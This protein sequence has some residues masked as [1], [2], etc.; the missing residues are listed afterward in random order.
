MEGAIII[1]FAPEHWGELQKF[2]EFYP[3]TYNLNPNTT[4]AVS[5]ALNHFSK[6]IILKNLSFKLKPNLE[7]DK[8]ELDK[9]GYSK[10]INSRELSAVIEAIILELYSSI[11]CTRK[12]VGEIYKNLQGVPNS[13]RKFFRNALENKLDENFPEQMKKAFK[14]ATWYNEF[15]KIRDELTH[16]DTG[17]CHLNRK[18]KKVFYTH[19]GF[20]IDNKALVIEDIFEKIEETFKDINELLS[21]V[22]H[23][24]NS[25][26]SDKEVRQNCGFFD[27]KVYSQ[28]VKPIDAIDFNSGRCESFEW[29]EKEE[30]PTCPFTASCGAY[31]RK[32]KC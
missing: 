29:F 8:K 6:A 9:N 13:T 28:F 15:R 4:K 3:Q 16:S 14:E 17:S 31:L 1:K 7:I 20:K 11:D 21:I 19:S 2:K 10:S 18:T 22:Y 26:L 23:F 12:V 27:G 5:G 32:S 25:Q 24:L 30:N